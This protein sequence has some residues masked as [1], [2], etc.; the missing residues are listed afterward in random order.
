MW[1]NMSRHNPSLEQK[2]LLT[3]HSIEIKS[4]FVRLYFYHN[5]FI[6]ACVYAYVDRYCK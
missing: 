3:L 5:G 6:F 2:M 1:T 4:E